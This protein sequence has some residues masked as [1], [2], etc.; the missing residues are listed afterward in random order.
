MRHYTKHAF[1]FLLAFA[2]LAPLTG[3]AQQWKEF[4]LRPSYWRPYDQTGINVF[5]TSKQPDYIAF[6]GPRVRIGARFTQQFQNLK[7]SNKLAAD[8]G[9]THRLVPVT[10]GFMTAQ[11][12]L[13]TDIQLAEGIRLN[14]TTYLSSRHHNEA[15]VKGGYIQ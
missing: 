9:N 6:E 2:F 15:W 8:R 1:F 4:Y 7:Q 10:A 5:E 12:N 3:I 11:A 13:Y 14:V